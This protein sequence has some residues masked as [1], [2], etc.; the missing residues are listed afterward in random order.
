VNELRVSSDDSE[1]LAEAQREGINV[2]GA[3]QFARDV[4]A[5]ARARGI[6][7]HALLTSRD[8]VDKSWNGIPI[9]RVDE[10][11][12]ADAPTW[13][14]VFNREAHS[15]HATLRQ[16][17]QGISDAARLVWPQCYYGL[18]QEQLG[19]RF[20]LH[21][22][23]GYP[24]VEPQLQ[25]ARNLLE[26]DRSRV[27]FDEVLGYRRMTSADW[28]SPVPHVDVQYLPAWLRLQ[29]GEPLRIV[30]GGAFRGETLRE[31][32]ALLPVQQAWTFEP[33]PENYAALVQ[34]QADWPVPTTHVPA[35]L[36]DRSAVA[37]FAAGLGEASSLTQTGALQVPVVALDQCLHR[38]PV[39]FIKL[40]V[41]GHE[42]AALHGAKA[43]LKRERPTL[44]IAGYHRWDDLWRI[45]V[46][47]ADLRLD[48]RLRIGL[49]GHN[50]FDTVFYAY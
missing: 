48:Y 45:P 47:I 43:T 46:F 5:A 28:R 27:A 12:L 22:L 9:R 29:I 11:T 8:P 42:L 26:D 30:D 25:A 33:D 32:A 2:F 21:S 39:N 35:G 7:V 19:S 20:W 40:D 15:D 23:G 24:T 6:N 18:L 38:A 41:E 14:G 49:H 3:G 13:I 34:S 44:A 1:W 4:T 50:S 10:L 37:G 36:S 17:L 31:L 16:Q